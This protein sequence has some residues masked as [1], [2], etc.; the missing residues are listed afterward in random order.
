MDATVEAIANVFARYG[1]HQESLLKI[2]DDT[3]NFI[4][5]ELRKWYDI[6]VLQNV[7]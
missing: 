3:V 6:K 1:G 5:E 4:S 2:Y 7:T